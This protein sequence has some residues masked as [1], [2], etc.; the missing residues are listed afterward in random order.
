MEKKTLY[1]S[2]RLITDQN[3]PYI[4][5]GFGY[6]QHSDHG[7][8]VSPEDDR[9]IK[10]KTQHDRQPHPSKRSVV[11]SLCRLKE[12]YDD[13]QSEQGKRNVS[14]NS[15]TERRIWAQPAVLREEA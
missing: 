7:D 1:L 14:V 6:H 12:Q 9:D 13:Q 4:C 3:S 5:T 15:P 8:H 10:S 11:L 2:H